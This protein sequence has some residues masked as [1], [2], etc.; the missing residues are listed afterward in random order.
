MTADETPAAK[1]H[2]LVRA[3]AFASAFPRAVAAAPIAPGLSEIRPAGAVPPDSGLPERVTLTN[4]MVDSTERVR[5][6]ETV[7]SWGAEH[8]AAEW[9]K[10]AIE[11]TALVRDRRDPGIR[12]LWGAWLRGMQRLPQRE[13]RHHLFANSDRLGPWLRGIILSD[14]TPA[15]HSLS[16]LLTD[17]FE[18]AAFTAPPG[19]DDDTP[20]SVHT[21]EGALQADALQAG[22]SGPLSVEVHSDIV[23]MTE[24]ARKIIIRD[25][26]KSTPAQTP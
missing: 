23:L 24:S 19:T 8:S 3:I 4:F 21:P 12:T 6:A 26:R 25:V 7:G 10:G 2:P 5:L 17:K 13:I 11:L 9:L 15:L 22:S 14:G 20:Y 18:R 16:G 1:K